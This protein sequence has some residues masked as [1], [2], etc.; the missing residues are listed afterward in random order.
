MD[1]IM[2]NPHS[3]RFQTDERERERG[4]IP[5][6]GG[7][8]AVVVPRRPSWRTPMCLASNVNT[9]ELRAQLGQLHSEAETA[10]AKANN[11]RLRLLRLSEAAEKLKRQAAVNVQAGKEDDARELL[12]QKKKVMEA[13]EK[14]K[15]RIEFLDELSTKLNEAISLKEGQLIGNVS[16][17]LEVVREDAFSPVRIVS[18][19]A[20]V[21]ENL[22]VGKEFVSNDLKEETPLLKDSQAS[23][24]VE[25]EGED[26]R[27]PLNRGAWNEDETL[28]SLKGLTSFNSF[29]E[30]LDHQLKKIEAELITILRISTLVVDGQ[31]KSRNFKVQKTMELLDSV[32]GV[33]QRISSIKMANVEAR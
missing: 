20:E 18:P 7:G 33:R 9:E 1:L 17:D 24:P 14:S 31:E 21:A 32:S 10:R 12:F 28:S 4:M 11:A 26:L 5:W 29:L 27:E 2:G 22:E 15:H 25:P 23:L 19:T 16:L 30:H 6:S 8:T 3:S 13:L